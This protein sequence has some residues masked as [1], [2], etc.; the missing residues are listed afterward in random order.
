MLAVYWFNPLCWLAYILLC[1][2]IEA[3]CDERVIRDRDR[4][5]VA[6]YSQALLECSNH[7]RVIAVCPLSF[8]ETGVKA[9]VKGV[10]NYKKPAF[11]VIVVSVTTCAIIAGCFLTTPKKT[12][13]A[14]NIDATSTFDEN[15]SKAVQVEIKR[16][17]LDLSATEGA[18][19]TQLLF[20]DKD[21]I[22]FSGYYGLFVYSKSEKVITI[23]VDLI[24]IGCNYTQGDNCCMKYVSADGNMIYLHPMGN[25]DMYVYNI[26]KDILVKKP[27]DMSGI[28][29]REPD[30]NEV[31][32]YFYA[33]ENE[34]QRIVTYLNHGSTIGELG[35][36]EEW[37]TGSDHCMIFSPDGSSGTIDFSAEE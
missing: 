2:D 33:W 5:Y 6:S 3:A 23:A 7:R 31:G 8:G 24:S 34:G 32:E 28:D 25:S 9:R 30:V 10:L 16:P 19:P 18:D 17:T 36:I 35:Y 15:D 29:Y 26:Q 11:W 37:E 12:V 13:S 27:F 4:D 20:A 14:G 22:I 1:R 21:R